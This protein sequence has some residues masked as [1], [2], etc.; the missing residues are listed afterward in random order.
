MAE[1]RYNDAEVAEIF[2]RAA[3]VP[4]AQL[5]GTATA[6]ARHGLTL[7]ELQ[8]IGREVGI[9]PTAI[10][11][12]A[13]SVAHPGRPPIRTFLG[14][15]VGVA[16]TVQLPRR[17]SDS[18]WERLVVDLRETFDARGHVASHGSLRQWSNGNLQVLLEPSDD[19]QRLRIRTRKGGA[20][21]AIAGGLMMVGASVITL[22]MAASQGAMGD[23]GM[24]AAIGS[25]GVWGAGM[26]AMTA[27]RLPRWARAR[28]REMEEVAARAVVAAARPEGK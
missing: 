18:E 21:G 16:H 28:R 13:E 11:F 27:L 12:A 8:E 17:L 20:I 22:S 2:R 10:A 23:T 4:S 5:Q 14:L 7:A 19:T 24:A 6:A 9:A 25:L 3:E 1:L 26:F 15:P